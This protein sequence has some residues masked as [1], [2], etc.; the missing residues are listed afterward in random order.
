MTKVIHMDTDLAISVANQLDR[1]SGDFL[2]LTKLLGRSVRGLEWQGKGREE[3]IRLFSDLEKKF[4]YTAEQGSILSSRLRKEV[5]EWIQAD[6]F[7]AETTKTEMEKKITSPFW[8][9]V[10]EKGNWAKG[11]IIGGGVVVL[12]GIHTLYSVTKDQFGRALDYSKG[13]A[14]KAINASDQYLD[15][16]FTQLLGN[17]T[18]GSKET[19]TFEAKG[20]VAIPGIEIGIPGSPK[21]ASAS[22]ISLVKENGKYKLILAGEVGGGVEEPLAQAKVKAKLGSKEYGVGFDASAEALAKER[23]EVAYDFDPKKPGDMSKMAAFMFGIG[24]ASSPG[25]APLVSPTLY[26]MKDNLASV[27]VSSGSEISGKADASVLVKLAGIDAEVEAMG[28]KEI[29]RAA[30][31]GWE[32]VSKTELGG[33]ANLNV[34]TFDKGV[35]AKATLESIQRQSDGHQSVKVIL[36]MKAT[37]GQSIK[38]EDISEYLPDSAFDKLS[39]SGGTTDYAGVQV[40]YTLDAPVETV[41]HIFENPSEGVNWNALRENSNVVVHGTERVEHGIGIEGDIGLP[42]QKI[43]IGGEANLVRESS[44]IIYSTE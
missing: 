17:P 31:G 36:D 40:E 43:G 30:D 37:E 12:D 29:R 25:A 39:I 1:T 34:L 35:E 42:S 15:N 20:D 7:G 26:S 13:Q 27:D 4:K 23:I 22:E 5:D 6:H 24:A 11:I 44:K 41:Q 9:W 28:G 18:K 2:Q 10:K 33:N 19:I 8:D 16:Q 21:V 38:F 14:K 3:Y 32:I